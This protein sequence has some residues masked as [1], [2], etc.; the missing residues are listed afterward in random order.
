[1]TNWRISM[2][3]EVKV[4]RIVLFKIP[5][6]MMVFSNEYPRIEALKKDCWWI[7]EIRGEALHDKTSSAAKRI[8]PTYYH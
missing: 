8:L 2:M 3:N 5:N 4:I 7:F 1:M 6:I